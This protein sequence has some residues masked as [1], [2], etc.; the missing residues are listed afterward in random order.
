MNYEEFLNDKNLIDELSSFLE[1]YGASGL[2]DA[3]Q[4]YIN[5]QQ[6]YICK[7]KNSISKLK[8]CDIYYVEIKEHHITI[9][10]QHDSFQKYGSLNNELTVLSP[11]GFVRCSQSCIVA[12]QKIKTICQDS[13]ILTNNT[14]IHMSRSYIPK[15][16]MAFHK[17]N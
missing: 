10:T 13:I 7:S 12:I 1:Q 6:E 14:N 15:V 2:R 11:Y 4:C 5:M 3:L 16:I 17:S 8:I 9:H